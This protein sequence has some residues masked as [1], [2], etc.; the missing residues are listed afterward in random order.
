MIHHKPLRSTWSQLSAV[1]VY[2]LLFYLREEKANLW[3][4]CMNAA[5]FFPTDDPVILRKKKKRLLPLQNVSGNCRPVRTWSLTLLVRKSG[6]DK[7][8]EHTLR[9]MLCGLSEFS[10][11]VHVMII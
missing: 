6:F 2:I 1:S 7:M 5:F 4:S 10:S 3:K 9:Q 11:S 8:T